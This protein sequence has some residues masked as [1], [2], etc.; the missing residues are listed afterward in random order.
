MAYWPVETCTGT[1]EREL[2][3]GMIRRFMKHKVQV[4]KMA[5]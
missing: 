5:A 4:I 1:L 2:Q 3:V